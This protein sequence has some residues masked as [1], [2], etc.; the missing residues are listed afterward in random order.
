MNKD[1]KCEYCGDVF[2]GRVDKRFCDSA[3][4]NAY[5]NDRNA[6]KFVAFR[7]VISRLKTNYRLLQL[8]EQES[9]RVK[10]QDLSRLGFSFDTVTH[11]SEQPEGLTK[12]CFDLAYRV[13]G[14]TVEIFRRPL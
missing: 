2:T 12:C 9:G 7:P 5:H 13:K 14:E 10:V 4:R 11:L 1:R 8:M 3:C 6:G